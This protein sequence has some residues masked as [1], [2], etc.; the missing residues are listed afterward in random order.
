MIVAS[1][2]SSWRA[3]CVL[4]TS[5]PLRSMRSFTWAATSR[6]CLRSLGASD[7]VIST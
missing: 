5:R 4:Y 2:C 7:T 3:T 1:G 6:I